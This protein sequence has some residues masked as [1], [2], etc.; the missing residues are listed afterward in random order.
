MTTPEAIAALS[1]Q[2]NISETDAESVL[3]GF[4]LSAEDLAYV[5]A[6]PDRTAQT[7]RGQCWIVWFEPTSTAIC[8]LNGTPQPLEGVQSL[9]AAITKAATEL[10]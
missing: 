4:Q 6:H 10:V 5:A 3:E 2:H 7:L 8:L 1:Q 9:S